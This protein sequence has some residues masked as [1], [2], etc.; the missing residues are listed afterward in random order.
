MEDRIKRVSKEFLNNYVDN[1]VEKKDLPSGATLIYCK[2]GEKYIGV[3]NTTNDCWVEEFNNETDVRK[4]LA[5]IEKED[6]I[7]RTKSDG[8]NDR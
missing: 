4:W 2:D 3:D 1:W 7:S 8:R 6:I 5:G